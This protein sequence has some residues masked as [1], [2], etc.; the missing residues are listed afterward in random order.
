MEIIM[1]NK[2]THLIISLIFAV[3]IGYMASN[4]S[5]VIYNH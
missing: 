5:V 3:G 4:D 2:I 1:Q